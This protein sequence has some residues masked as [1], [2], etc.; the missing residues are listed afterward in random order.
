MV[1]MSKFSK[2]S[3]IGFDGVNDVKGFNGWAA[4]QSCFDGVGGFDGVEGFDGW[5]RWY[6]VEVFEGFD[7]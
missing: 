1:S 6:R 7:D 5:L 2:A 4:N 3:M